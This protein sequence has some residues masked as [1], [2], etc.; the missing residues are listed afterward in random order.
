[1]QIEVKGPGSE[2][3][4]FSVNVTRINP[5]RSGNVTGKQTFVSFLNSIKGRH[6]DNNVGEM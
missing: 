6:V 2:D 5:A 4:Y 1:M 3:N